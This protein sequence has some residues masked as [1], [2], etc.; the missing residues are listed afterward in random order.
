MAIQDGPLQGAAVD[1]PMKDATIDFNLLVG[2]LQGAGH[3]IIDVICET[4]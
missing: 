1:F 3:H 2:E 4:G